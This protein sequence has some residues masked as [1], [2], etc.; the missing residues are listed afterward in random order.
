[1]LWWRRRHGD[2]GKGTCFINTWEDFKAEIKEQLYP[3]NVEQE[4]RGRLRSLTHKGS[5]RDY[6][7]EFT[8]ILLEILDLP[9][10]EA[11]FT[12]TDGLQPWAKLE[13]QRRGVQDLAST[14]AAA[15][16][17]IKFRKPESTKPTERR[18]EH[19]GNGGGDHGHYRG[20][21]SKSPTHSKEV[22]GTPTKALLDTGASH[23]FLK[24]NEA[25]KLGIKFKEE[26]GWI[27]AVNSEARPIYG[28]TSV[29]LRL[30]E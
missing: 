16:S 11:L 29:N 30:G 1:M 22:S 19:N 3:E 28:V 2:I 10:K 12:F 18:K 24:V 8:E 27:K 20:E 13:L 23:N 21:S 9:D 15:E 26:Q 7:K 6:V 17:L 5:V 14:I 4:A 25:R